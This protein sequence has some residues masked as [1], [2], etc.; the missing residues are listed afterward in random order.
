LLKPVWELNAVTRPSMGSFD[1]L[2][3]NFD[4]VVPIKSKLDGLFDFISQNAS[5]L[6]GLTG[7]AT[8]MNLDD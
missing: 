7:W 8:N 4:L 3:S 6:Q 1:N 2:R 5:Y